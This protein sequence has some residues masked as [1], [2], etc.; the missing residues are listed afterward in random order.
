VEALKA[1][2]L[3]WLPEAPDKKLF[4]TLSCNDDGEMRLS[5]FGSFDPSGR[6]PDRRYPTILGTTD[7]ERKY[8]EVTLRDCFLSKQMLSSGPL[9]LKQ[10][11]FAHRAFL[12]DQLI[13]ESEFAFKTASVSFSG[14]SEWATNFTG[15][16]PDTQHTSI[17]WENPALLS[18]QIPGGT[19]TLGVGCESSMGA[20]ERKIT[21]DVGI[22]LGFSTAIS[23]NDLSAKIISPF[24]NFFTL[25]TDIPNAMT[26]LT[27]A[28]EPASFDN[29]TVIGPRIFSD[30]SAA[31][32]L[33]PFKML[34]SLDDVRGR[35]ERVFNRWLDI[36]H[37]FERA[38]VVYFAGIYNPA[39]Y[40]DL[41]FQ[42]IMT[43]LALYGS[44]QRF[45]VAECSTSMD[46]LLE[47]LIGKVPDTQAVLLKNL[48]KSHPIVAAER[49]LIGLLEMHKNEM[50]PL[51]TDKDGRGAD[52]FIR[53]VLNTLAFTMT[54]EL[55]DGPFAA[56]GADLHWLTE[57]TAFLVKISLLK[58][59][60]FTSEEVTKILQ[61]NRNFRHLADHVQP[62][63]SWGETSD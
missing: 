18:G 37:R 47:N 43:V 48:F 7:I 3:W 30:E 10:E 31:K 33:M 39:E 13:T 35:L 4:G 45:G 19:F 59:L 63:T 38:L 53:Y 12:G 28:H 57:R 16:A 25:A 8:Q 32:D 55:P 9:G 27:V 56:E 14:L 42:H 2:G 44:A 49:A 26:R 61:R 52:A 54:R 1:E 36:S 11:F 22:R 34:F 50:T 29:I 60:E 24:Q 40:S 46:Q 15:F 62:G 58:E 51:V 5:V 23:E 41:R 6:G 21:E 20:R 17:V